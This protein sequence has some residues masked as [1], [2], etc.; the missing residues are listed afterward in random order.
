MNN[1][2]INDARHIKEFLL[3]EGPEV[4]DDF[5]SEFYTMI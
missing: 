4:Y 1:D 2:E 3:K 5:Y